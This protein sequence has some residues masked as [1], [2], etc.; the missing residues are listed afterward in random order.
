[1]FSMCVCVFFALAS[2]SLVFQ[3][4]RAKWHCQKVRKTTATINHSTTT[5][6]NNIEGAIKAKILIDQ[7]LKRVQVSGHGN[8]PTCKLHLARMNEKIVKAKR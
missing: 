4:Q 3:V 6:I 2:H 7:A 1:M 5:I 8:G